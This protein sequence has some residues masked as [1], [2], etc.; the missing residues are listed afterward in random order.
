M[1]AHLVEVE[2]NKFIK[3]YQQEMRLLNQRITV[4]EAEIK[5]LKSAQPKKPIIR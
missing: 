2:L 3:H 1:S 4:L 5:Q